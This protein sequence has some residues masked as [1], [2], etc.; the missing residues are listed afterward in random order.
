MSM[1]SVRATVSAVRR[2]SPVTIATPRPSD[3]RGGHG[4]RSAS[5]DRVGRGEHAGQATVDGDMN[6]AT[7]LFGHGIGGGDIVRVEGRGAP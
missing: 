3:R 6:G 5:P 4:A 2:L 1:P 7:G